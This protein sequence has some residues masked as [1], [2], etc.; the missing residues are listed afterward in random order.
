MGSNQ[1]RLLDSDIL[2]NAWDIHVH[3]NP[4]LFPR[5]NDCIEATQACISAKMN[6]LVLKSHHGSSIEMAYA[7][8]KQFIETKIFGGL[9][10]NCFVGGLNPFA[11]E[12]AVRMGAKIIWLPTIHADNHANVFHELGRFD[13]QNSHLS[14]T[15]KE[16]LSILDPSGQL[17]ESVRQILK[18]IHK[19]P[20]ALGTGHIS[21]QE[22]IA[23]HE[24]I[25]VENF[26][27]R[28]LINHVFF[29]I[30]CLS[31]E[32]IEALATDWTWFETCYFSIS[33]L[34]KTKTADE[35]AAAIKKLP[36][37]R[38][39]LASDSGQIQNPGTP[40]ALIT[41]ANALHSAGLERSTIERALKQEPEA[42]LNE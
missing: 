20:V 26:R 11:V 22:I 31:L 33:K 41:F 23:L 2:S 21:A 30:P 29:K 9:V 3:A 32:L 36:N 17:K 25:K 14:H 37:A 4:S 34:G 38:W 16:G 8:N 28:L 7:I 15:P 35:I 39:I 5:S 24:F 19:T 18:L 6:G 1:K 40:E 13:F 27:I 42:L 12:S 10:L